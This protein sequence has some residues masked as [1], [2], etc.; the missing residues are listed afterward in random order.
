MGQG[1]PGGLNRQFPGERKN[2]GD[3]K[4]KKFEP[5]PA[6]VGRKQRK[7]KAPRRRPGFRLLR[8]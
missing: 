6:R 7:Q 4:D 8:H 3:K 2:D 1:T 5:A